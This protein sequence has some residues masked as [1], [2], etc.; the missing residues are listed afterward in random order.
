VP[1]SE[2]LHGV[3]V[4]RA[5][6]KTVHVAATPDGARAL[7]DQL[8]DGALDGTDDFVIRLFIDGQNVATGQVASSRPHFANPS[9]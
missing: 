7:F 8:E 9:Y 2:L 3:I 5:A 6:G 4:E 1:A